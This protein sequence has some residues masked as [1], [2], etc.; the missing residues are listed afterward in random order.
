MAGTYPLG[1]MITGMSGPRACALATLLLVAV[2]AAMPSAA[3]QNQ[4]QAPS[5]LDVLIRATAY[6]DE[7]LDQL[8]GTVSEERYV[9]RTRLPGNRGGTVLERTL[10]SDFLIVTPEDADRHYGFRDVFEVDGKAV[11]DREERLTN[12]FLN[13]TVSSARQI[14]G[15]LNESSR[16]NLGEVDRTINNPALTL[17]FLSSNFK[18]RFEFERLTDQLSP[19]LNLDG[20]DV[21]SDAW[22]IS[23]KEVFPTTVVKRGKGQGGNLPSQGRFW[24]DPISGHVFVSE[25]TLETPQWKSIITVRYGVDE[26]AGQVVPVEMRERY[27]AQ[28]SMSRVDG[29]A[30]YGRFRRFRVEVDEGKPFRD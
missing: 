15:I 7:L 14:E 23:Y 5:L 10:L 27:D 11:R 25:L 16:Y 28:R 24:I 19:S 20:P 29:T 1:P 9:Q 2:F 18:S 6:V 3:T 22:V 30:T 12:L 26:R 8:S 4:D 21:P 13:P 17:L